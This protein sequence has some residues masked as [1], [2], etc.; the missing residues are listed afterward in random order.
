MISRELSVVF[1][2]LSWLGS[3]ES[4]KLSL[5]GSIPE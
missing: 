5:K 4:Q 3:L 1:L 2:S